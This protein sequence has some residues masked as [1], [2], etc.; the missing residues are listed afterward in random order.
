MSVTKILQSYLAMTPDAVAIASKSYDKDDVSIAYIN[1]SYTRLFGYTP[2][3]AVGQP[4]RIGHDPDT[5]DEFV[6]FVEPKFMAGEEHFL[7][8]TKCKR[9]DGSTFWTSISFFVVQDKEARMQYTCATYR[10]INDLKDREAA[11]A[12]S[13]RERASLLAKQEQITKEVRA[14]Q[15]RL[16]AAI[17][18]YPAPFVIY[19][20]DKVLVTCNTAYQ[21]SMSKTPDK[22]V[23]GMHITEVLHEAWDCNLVPAPVDGRQSF[24]DG[25]LA[26]QETHRIEDIELPGD[27][28]QRVLR[29]KADNGDW[30]NIRLDIT[31]L[32]RERRQ[33]NDL[34]ERMMA[35][36]N[37]YP[38][39]FSIFD[40]SGRLLLWNEAFA[41]L[42]DK[43]GT[44]LKAGLSHK[45]I[46]KLG[47]RRGLFGQAYV[48]ESERLMAREGA[49]MHYVDLELPDGTHFRMRRS[50]APNGD[51]VVIHQNTTEQIHQQR[52]AEASQ[53][54][55]L[56]AI[57]AYPAPFCIYDADDRLVVWN[58]SYAAS[59]TDTPDE[60]QQGMYMR[61]VLQLGLRRERF[62]AAIGQED[63][64][65]DRI[66]AD[67]AKCVPQEDLEL[68]EGVYQRLMRSRTANGDLVMLRL[69][70]TELVRKS[71]A[72]EKSQNRLVS[73]LNAFPDPF[74]IYDEGL[75]LVVWNAAFESN[76]SDKP[77][78]FKVGMHVSD[79][80]GIAIAEGQI[81]TAIGREEEWLKD[82]IE[83]TASVTGTDDMAFANGDHFR[84]IR[85][86]TSTG[87][88][89][90]MR[91]N[92]TEII[93]QRRALEQYANRL[94]EANRKITKEALH[95]QLTGLG[96]RR[97]LKE[98]FEE[99]SAERAIKGGELAALHIDLDRFKQI[100]DTIGH[101]AGDHVLVDV[102]NRIL[103]L[104]EDD[105]IVARIGG[106][107]FI[108]LMRVSSDSN[109]PEDL[110]R[111]LIK[112]LSVPSFFEG[113]ECRFGCS[114]GIAMTPLAREE[115]LLTN[116]DVA[117]YNAKKAGRGQHAIFNRR[118]IEE[119]C[120]TKALADDI[121][122]GLDAQEF[123][124]FYQPQLDAITGDVVGIEAL[125]RWDHPDK[126][127]LSPDHFIHVASEMNVL[128]DIDRMIF[129]TAIKTCETAFSAYENIPSLSFNV[130]AKRL[131][132]Q[133][134][135]DI[136][137]MVKS[138]SGE[139]AFELLETIYL[140][141]ESDSFLMRL[142][143]L[144]ELGIA[145]EVDDFGSGRASIVAL[146]RI[147][148]DRLKIDQRLVAPM[149][150]G[151]NA[152]RLV[153]SIIDIG[154]ALNIGVIAE[155]VETS[156]H[157]QLLA[158]LGTER[159]QGYYISK[160]V[161]LHGLV[162]F[163]G[164]PDARHRAS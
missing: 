59:L 47:L 4:A 31:E 71:Q 42:V 97:F 67:V 28:H 141:E 107:E 3:E 34:H 50:Q 112:A 13:L 2:G 24:I 113:R 39:P 49:L 64:W 148:P 10:D 19:D 157:V 30:V 46:L 84:S 94:E 144:R 134:I 17:N 37:A 8:E 62:T 80:L 155:G 70:T 105:E 7:V 98:K 104:K 11:A 73:A 149:R 51:Q 146:Q 100:N 77:D 147:A 36:L 132:H 122:R 78:Q 33:S 131:E 95:D 18:A 164:V 21:E 66:M 108:V 106:D 136:G 138:Y 109:R 129:E 40:E 124:P 43:D 163:L 6:A 110:A 82:Y 55:L 160:P 125:A 63:Q 20:K 92:I 91:I 156:E 41:S 119:M 137:Q 143:Q 153:K 128:A 90:V 130:S 56:S 25:L 89:V 115:D 81:P 139:V 27:L 150:T 72:L 145:I 135:L 48:R 116:S 99:V 1:A 68:A 5:W 76:L 16:L 23:P 26:K 140:E 114:V 85:S 69:D 44:G 29:S 9:S 121:I 123:V 60:V 79:V 52:T 74:A 127:I 83:N 154:K 93:H 12:E 117:L 65:L 120:E 14:T 88:M 101:N 126:G 102:A 96:N 38:D 161:P 151:N 118:D 142:D 159:L 58:E 32:V 86:R 162:A 45:D 22:I 158:D 75:H 103:Q 133:E 61:D 15:K 54:R 35:A 111:A 53:N 152:T 57:S 87:E